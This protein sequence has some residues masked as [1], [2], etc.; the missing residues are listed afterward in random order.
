MSR[1]LRPN[2]KIEKCAIKLTAPLFSTNPAPVD[3]VISP[4]MQ[5][6]LLGGLDVIDSRGHTPEHI[7]FFSVSSGILFSGDSIFLKHGRLIP[8]YGVNCW[9]ETLSKASFERQM[10]LNP[11][12]ICGGHMLWHRT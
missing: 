9:N 2:N 6:N 3:I 7:S 5:F 1:E 8:S 12:W 4:G 10:G 11:N